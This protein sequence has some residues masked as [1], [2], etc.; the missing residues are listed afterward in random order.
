MKRKIFIFGEPHS[1]KSTLTNMIAKKFGYQIIR[2]DCERNAL[3]EI[4]KEL[5]I[6]SKTAITNERFQLYLKELVFSTGVMEEM[7]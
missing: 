3:K 5:N 4:F 6:N 1:G 2:S 7:R